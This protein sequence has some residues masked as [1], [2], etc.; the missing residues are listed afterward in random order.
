MSG[1]E[2]EEIIIIKRYANR[3][4]YDTH[5]SQYVNL[6]KIGQMVKD[7]YRLQVIDTKTNKDITK[8]ILTQIILD[9]EKEQKSG[10]PLEL[11]FGLVKRGG[12]SYM[13]VME[14]IFSIG[15]KAYDKTIE[16]VKST[17]KQKPEKPSKAQKTS[18]ASTQDEI[19]ELKNRL[20][21]VEAM[22]NSSNKKDTKQ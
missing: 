16:K 12:S 13:G 21:E 18:S 5:S 14:D 2:Q 19:R 4:L 15:P 9:N 1:K 17:L 22:L 8:T 6:G 20:A 10:V 3:R 11:L 7:G